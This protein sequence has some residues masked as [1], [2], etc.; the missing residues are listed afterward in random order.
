MAT[1]RFS[2]VFSIIQKDRWHRSNLYDD[3]PMYF[4]Q[5]L[6][7]S[8]V[9]LHQGIVPNYPASHGCIR[10]PEAFARNSCGPPRRTGVRV[11]VSHGQS[12]ASRRS[13]VSKLLRAA[14]RLQP[15]IASQA[16]RNSLSAAEQAWNLAQLAAEA[17]A[18]VTI[19]PT[20]TPG[21]SVLEAGAAGRAPLEAGPVSVF[22][23]RKEGKLFVRKGLSWLDAWWRP[24]VSALAFHGHGAAR[25]GAPCP[26]DFN[27]ASLRAWIASGVH[28]SR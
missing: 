13:C 12:G 14:S 23:S 16:C 28:G 21:L 11:I 26:A 9:A 8:G 18:W 7:W 22:I 19:L 6:T 2:G 5:R 24:I 10:L 20:P 17:I 1:Q 3:A 25:T 15:A 4:M 27:G